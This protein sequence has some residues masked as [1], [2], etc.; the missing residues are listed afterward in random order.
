MRDTEYKICGP[1]LAYDYYYIEFK[2]KLGF[3]CKYRLVPDW[4]PPP[5]S[6]FVVTY[7]KRSDAQNVITAL[8]NGTT[9]NESTS[10][11]TESVILTSCIIIVIMCVVTAL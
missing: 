11:I 3:W 8:Q 4:S 2:N 10:M 6:A 7:R 5:G 9:R 1:T